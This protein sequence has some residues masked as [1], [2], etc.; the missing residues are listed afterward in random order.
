MKQGDAIRILLKMGLRETRGKHIELSDPRSG[1]S[2]RFAQNHR[3]DLKPYQEK[4]IKALIGEKV[5]W[6]KFGKS[7]G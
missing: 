4:A 6:E 2:V 3:Q 1:K 5:F 7:R